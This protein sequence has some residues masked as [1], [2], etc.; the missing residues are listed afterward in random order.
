MLKISPEINEKYNHL[1][2]RL[3]NYSRI[4]IAFSGGVDSSLLLKIAHDTVGDNTLA[5][6]A[7]SVV[8]TEKERQCAVS[9]AQDIGAAL[10]RVDFDPLAIPEFAT[11]TARRC[12][13]CKN[14]VFSA[15]K[16]LARQ[17]NFS[18]L[19]DG[20]N[21]DD[22]STERPGMQAVIEL[23]VKSPLAEAGLTKHEIR[24]L[25]QALGLATWNKHSASCLATRVETNTPITIERLSNI[26]RAEQYLHQLGYQGCRVRLNGTAFT[27]ELSSGDISRIPHNNDYA[28]IRDFFFSLGAKKVFLDLSERESILSSL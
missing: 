13:H 22:L 10:Q 17:Q 25:S 3:R 27:V 20:T 1:K 14:N 15:F 5:L 24:I 18:V 2:D 11:N 12:Y 9:T 6:F 19:A 16:E 21:L 7:D 28:R 23:G 8:Q 26:D 4:A